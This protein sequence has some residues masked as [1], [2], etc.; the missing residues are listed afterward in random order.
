MN[1]RVGHSPVID[2]KDSQKNSYHKLKVV[3]TMFCNFRVNEEMNCFMFVVSCNIVHL[4]LGTYYA[5]WRLLMASSI[6]LTPNGLTSDVKLTLYCRP[7]RFGINQH[8]RHA[9]ANNFSI[10]SNIPQEG[11]HAVSLG[12]ICF[13]L[14]LW[15]RPWAE[16][17]SF[18]G[19]PSRSNRNCNVFTLPIFISSSM[20]DWL[21]DRCLNHTVRL[22][23][24]Q[25][26]LNCHRRPV[27]NAWPDARTDKG[28]WD[29]TMM[30]R[31]TKK[32][33]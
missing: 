14:H 13:L 18:R 9:S 30:K 5:Y 15:V 4:H 7:K 10:S 24:F 26:F 32:E 17:L 33:V 16:S 1:S 27:G 31:C 6:W 22:V 19:L 8:T 21:L 20:I 25:T 2:D 11:L 12:G 28:T 23:R 29:T 3:T